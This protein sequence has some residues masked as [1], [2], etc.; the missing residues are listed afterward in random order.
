VRRLG[1]IALLLVS[2]GLA[3]ALTEASGVGTA[4]STRSVATMPTPAR[5][6][7]HA[8]GPN[9]D[10][11]ARL[12][13]NDECVT[14]HA[15]IA[16]EWTHSLHRRAYEDPMFQA[17]IQRE[18]DPS[19]CRACH[20]PEADPTQEPTPRESA[21]GVA[22]V[23]CHLTGRDPAVLASPDPQADDSQVPHALRRTAAFASPEAC[24][25]C[26]EFWFPSSGR[27]GHALK[28]QR[29]LSEHA[30]SA[31]ADESCQRCHM[32]P[33]RSDAA[34]HMDHMDHGFAVVG[35]PSMLRAAVAIAATRPEPGRVV[36]ELSPRL[37]GHAFPTGDLFRRLSVE[38]HS[39]DVG[40]SWSAQRVLGRQFGSRRVGDG[41]V[42]RVE[43]T[44]DR[45]GASSGST[46]VEFE[47][48]P[49]LHGAPVV[50]ELVHERALEAS[51]A[52]AGQT[53]VWDRT[54]FARGSL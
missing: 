38:L 22:C 45:V 3:A 30:R 9:T 18:R 28:M 2:F 29:T 20:A 49:E 12:D 34:V 1:P 15:D 16:G 50:W 33:A 39:D 8:R 10:A 11:H 35:Q 37:V 4:T 13:R 42:I 7:T 41:Q 32:L 40:P 19:F 24:G 44:D 52:T 36:L 5:G 53:D 31:F 43:H 47:L 21:A 51:G 46:I 54:S 25:G 14:C 27:A 26:H 17:A 23:S 48:P 6:P